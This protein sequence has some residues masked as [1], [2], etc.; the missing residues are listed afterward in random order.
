M[1]FRTLISY[2]IWMMLIVLTG[3][4]V[5]GLVSSSLTRDPNSVAAIGLVAAAIIL[6]GMV[7]Y[8]VMMLHGRRLGK[9]RVQQSSYPANIEDVAP[10]AL[11]AELAETDALLRRG[12]FTLGSERRGLTAADGGPTPAW[13]YH[14]SDHT[15][16]ALI[17]LSANGR[18]VGMLLTST[19]ADETQLT[20]RLSRTIP[21]IEKPGYESHSVEKPEDIVRVH[22]EHV[23][24]LAQTLGG[25][26]S[27]DS[28]EAEHRLAAKTYQQNMGY[29]FDAM[30]RRNL[31]WLIAVDGIGLLALA[32]GLFQLFEPALAVKG[33]VILVGGAALMATLS[34]SGLAS[35]RRSAQLRQGQSK[36]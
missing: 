8:T 24:R 30:W 7:S 1:N 19:F 21:R 16:Q 6:V 26:L 12:G 36:T 4:I 11:P 27:L 9:E 13:H 5:F 17:A 3:L 2:F 25:P 22:N 31:V 28:F 15:V 34:L 32:S 10:G 18:E 20:T 33:L 23:Q 35:L 14:N 29:L